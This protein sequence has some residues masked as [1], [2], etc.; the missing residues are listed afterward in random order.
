[1]YLELEITRIRTGIRFGE[2]EKWKRSGVVGSGSAGQAGGSS[3]GKE[4]YVCVGGGAHCAHSLRAARGSSSPFSEGPGTGGGGTPSMG[5]DGMEMK[6]CY[7]EN[8]VNEMV[9]L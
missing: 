1:M 7:G 5:K 8:D 3:G 4:G 9:L 2:E 6:W